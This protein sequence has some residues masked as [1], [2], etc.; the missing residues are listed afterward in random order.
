MAVPSASLDGSCRSRSK[1]LSVVVVKP[2]ARVGVL[3]Q[4]QTQLDQWST[5][6][7]AVFTISGHK[8][9]ECKTDFTSSGLRGCT[10]ASRHIATN[11]RTVSLGFACVEAE[12]AA[13]QCIQ[14]GSVRRR[15]WWIGNA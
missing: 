5:Q 13:R 8:Q 3:R 12:W 10:P 1:A 6:D 2:H 11:S 14:H 15:E 9:W 7:L 4:R